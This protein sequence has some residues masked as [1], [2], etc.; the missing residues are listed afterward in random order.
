MHLHTPLSELAEEDRQSDR[1]DA[2]TY[3]LAMPLKGG[4]KS[5]Q[6]ASL[7][8]WIVDQ[9]VVPFQK[10]QGQLRPTMVPKY[11]AAT[12]AFLADL[13]TAARAG[14]WSKLATDN[15][16]LVAVPGGKTAFTTMRKALGAAG[17]LEELPGY[18]YT[19]TV[20]GRAKRRA[21]RTS[22]RPSAKLLALAE[23]HGVG[24]GDFTT[25]FTLG[26]DAV[27]APAEV[28]QLVA[29]KPEDGSEAKRLPFPADDPR[30]QP[31]IEAMERLNAYLMAEGRVTGIV[32]TGLRRSYSNADQEAF[33]YQWHGR[34]YSMP[35]A[36]PYERMVG[37]KE[38]RQGAI[39]IDGKLAREVDISAS[40][41][42]ILHGL[43]G[44]PFDPS[45]DPYAVP[46]V[47][48][49][50]V[51]Q[52]LV[53][54]LGSS[55]AANGGNRLKKAKEAGLERYPFLRQLWRY[56]IGPL[57]LQWHEAE[58]MR[59]AMEDLMERGLG[60]LPVHD[61]LLVAQGNEEVAAE[62][63]RSAFGRYFMES[64]GMEAA[65]VPILKWDR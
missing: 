15:N 49:E 57:D 23:E 21:A 19:E 60:F 38:T 37:G 16:H 6:A 43:L 28:L 12:E 2:R 63:I 22:F 27:P 48:R 33:D 46:R 18:Y 52:W 64:L 59:L 41:L 20:F 24:L 17:Y 13:L 58:I 26:R 50:W 45:G 34:F 51:K 25:H 3:S 54:A 14:K 10:S 62:A 65:P 39:R 4:V 8:A 40:H 47:D 42:T 35:E 31:I 11:R 61:A 32:F 55:G 56:G 36:D 5:P 53:L 44:L 30:A 7:V 1:R 9:I 29:T